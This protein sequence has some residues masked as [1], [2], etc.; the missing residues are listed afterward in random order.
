MS[1]ETVKTI[2]KV[3]ERFGIYIAVGLFAF[4]A[5]NG[6]KNMERRA[7]LLEQRNIMFEQRMKE[8]TDQIG[9]IADAQKKIVDQVDEKQAQER[10]IRMDVGKEI[11]EFNTRVKEIKK[12]EDP[13]ESIDALM[14]AW[15]FD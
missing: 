4:F 11:K 13:K 2:G 3:L 1:L 7:D 6:W 10:Q 15:N 5:F 12:I 14:R 9:K 8:W